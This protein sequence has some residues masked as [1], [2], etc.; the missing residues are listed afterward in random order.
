LRQLVASEKLQ[1]LESAVEVFLLTRSKEIAAKKKRKILYLDEELLEFAFKACQDIP[2]MKLGE[3]I[4]AREP[5][6]EL[7]L[8]KDGWR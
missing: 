4:K 3:S 5:E 6:N 7:K 2:E 1:E 8:I